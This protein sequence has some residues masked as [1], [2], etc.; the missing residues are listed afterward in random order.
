MAVSDLVFEMISIMVKDP[1][2]KGPKVDTALPRLPKL[3]M[4]TRD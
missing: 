3:S 2:L 4:K 1:G